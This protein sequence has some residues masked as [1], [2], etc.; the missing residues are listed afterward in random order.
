[1]WQTARE[2]LIGAAPEFEPEFADDGFC[3]GPLSTV[4]ASF[5]QERL[6]ASKFGIRFHL[7][8]TTLYLLAGERFE[9]D[10]RPFRDLGVRIVHGWD[11]RILQVPISGTS[12]FMKEFCQD[13]QQDL[14]KAFEAVETLP[15]RHVG[16]HLL[17]KC[18][19]IG[20]ISYGCR[21][22]PRV[23]I[24]SLLKWYSD[25]MRRSFSYLLG[26]DVDDQCWAQSTLPPKLGGLGLGDGNWE[27]GGVQVSIAD[28][29]YY[30]SW[31]FSTATIA[32]LLPTGNAGAGGECIRTALESLLP[33]FPDLPQREMPL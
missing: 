3:G 2:R 16:F 10:L 30:S 25:R 7:S 5:E 15:H 20:K 4:W 18:F 31:Q 28:I 26:Q 6:L 1:M 8:K 9:G 27:V 33:F 21:T 12:R 11:V 29:A 32:T 17:Q 23:H 19:G 22:V 13:M 24:Q 14:E